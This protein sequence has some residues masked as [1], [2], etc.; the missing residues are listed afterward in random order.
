ML[1]APV[2]AARP[3]LVALASIAWSAAD[4]VPPPTSALLVTGAIPAPEVLAVMDD[5]SVAEPE[6][7]ELVLEAE[8]PDVSERV[9]E[10]TPVIAREVGAIRSPEG[11]C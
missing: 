7:D 3:A 9:M 10:P 6:L 8:L 4:V 5:I 1:T 11:V 2:G